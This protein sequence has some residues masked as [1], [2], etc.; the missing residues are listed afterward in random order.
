MVDD[1]GDQKQTQPQDADRSNLNQAFESFLNGRRQAV[2]EGRSMNRSAEDV[3][4][5]L[6]VTSLFQPSHIPEELSHWALQLS[7]TEM[8]DSMLGKLADA[9]VTYL[10]LCWL[11]LPIEETADLLP[12]F[13]KLSSLNQLCIPHAVDVNVFQDDRLEAP[14]VSVADAVPGSAGGLPTL[15][16]SSLAPWPRIEQ[17]ATYMEEPG[18]KMRLTRMFEAF[19][20]N[21]ENWATRVDAH[22]SRHQSVASGSSHASAVMSE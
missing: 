18:H 6:D 14:M 5:T 21:T 8:R 22:R 16:A 11:I 2:S 3:L 9:Y 20:R 13:I 12:E 10:Q 4:P 15:L 17:E 7:L 1:S 19:V